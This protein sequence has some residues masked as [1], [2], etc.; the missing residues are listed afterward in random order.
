MEL[1]HD[2]H[3]SQEKNGS[4]TPTPKKSSRLLR[5]KRNVRIGGLSVSWGG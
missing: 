3:V 1:S 4:K 5:C 2:P